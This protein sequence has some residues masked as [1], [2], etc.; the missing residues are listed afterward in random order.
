MNEGVARFLSA[1]SSACHSS[2]EKFR[3]LR[4]EEFEIEEIEA[5]HGAGVMREYAL[6]LFYFRCA[7]GTQ[8]ES[9]R[10]RGA[11]ARSAKSSLC[12]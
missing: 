9:I 5:A 10:K 8:L 2:H 6:S 3:I 1:S 4:A 12:T 7:E 11:R